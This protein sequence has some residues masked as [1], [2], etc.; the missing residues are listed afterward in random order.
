VA[1]RFQSSDFHDAKN[2]VVLPEHHVDNSL[3]SDLQSLHFAWSIYVAGTEA[4][5]PQEISQPYRSRLFCSEPY[6]SRRFAEQRSVI[7]FLGSHRASMKKKF[8]LLH[9]HVETSSL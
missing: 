3:S 4:D 9:F 5:I 6:Q 8:L 7:V 1:F 2:V